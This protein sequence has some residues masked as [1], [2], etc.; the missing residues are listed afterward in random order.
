MQPTCVILVR[1][2]EEGTHG[3]QPD[4]LAVEEPL[5]I[6]LGF[7]PVD[8]RQQRPLS[9]TMRTPGHDPEL[10][11]G[12]LFSEGI[13][14]HY[15]D[16]MSVRHCATVTHP[17]ERDNTVRVELDPALSIDWQR[18]ERYSYTSSSCG[19]CGKTSIE[20]VNATYPAPSTS[21]F[22]V[23]S[24][25]IHAAPDVLRQA[26]LVF[27]H[28]GGLHAAGLF[29]PRGELLLWHEDVGRHNAL[30]KLLG[31]ALQQDR[32]PL[33][34]TF[35]LLSGRISFELVQKALM[36]GVPLLAAVGA[37]SSLAVQL[38]SHHGITLVGF[39][40]NQRFNI[41]TAAHRVTRPQIFH[42]V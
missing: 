8:S 31:A 3:T 36:A 25:A 21:D 30:D 28:T 40:R 9:V 16:V 32:L 15:R 11:L 24:E 23:A 27:K 20:A 29:N 14:R 42:T 5:A 41:Y 13:I 7:G 6:R 18:L 4:L 38:A 10:V 22:T 33:H 19:V 26:Q 39:V 17:S 12:F 37:P 35:V 1:Q 2:S 34:E